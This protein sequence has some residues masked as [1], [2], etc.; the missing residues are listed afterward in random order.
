MSET[1]QAEAQLTSSSE[2]Q[3]FDIG[4]RDGLMDPKHVRNMGPAVWLYMWLVRKMTRIDETKRLGHVLGGKPVTYEDIRL[5][6]GISHR[7]Y[8]RYIDLLRDH[9]YIV[10]TRTPRG[11]VIAVTKAKKS[12][13]VGKK[14]YANNDASLP[15]DTPKVANQKPS[16]TPQMAE[17]YAT[18]GESNIR[19]GNENKHTRTVFFERLKNIIQPKAKYSDAYGKLV[20]KALKTYSEDELVVSATFFV[21]QFNGGSEWH[22][23]QENKNLC[24][25][26][27][28]LGNTSDRIPRYQICFEKAQDAS[29]PTNRITIV[30]D[31]EI[32][33]KRQEQ[34]A[35]MHARRD[36]MLA[37]RALGGLA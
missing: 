17:R 6:L 27:Q 37:L 24:S 14:G 22:S 20:S 35:A 34:T 10:T 1:L 5:G 36:R 28:F 21:G 11:L 18:N 19:E 15:S 31:E 3:S 23:R 25:M 2:L 33:A 7:T 30:S 8:D 26:A 4:L 13:F 32:E 12:F 29:A 9:G 16:D